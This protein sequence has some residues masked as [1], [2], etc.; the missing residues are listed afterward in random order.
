M[1]LALSGARGRSSRKAQARGR[2][3]SDRFIPVLA[4]PPTSG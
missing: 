1:L 4:P 2:P 3:P